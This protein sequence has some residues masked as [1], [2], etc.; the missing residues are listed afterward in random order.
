MILCW[1]WK[2]FSEIKAADLFLRFCVCDVRVWV[3]GV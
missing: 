1:C 3:G 2:V